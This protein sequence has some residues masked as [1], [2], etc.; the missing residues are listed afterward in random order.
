MGKAVT[1]G[2]PNAERF[3]KA[4]PIDPDEM[5][6][7]IALAT[8]AATYKMPHK[9][10]VGVPVTL[11]MGNGEIETIKLADIPMNRGM[12]AIKRH[13]GNDGEKFFSA[14]LRFIALGAVYTD[15]RCE[16]YVRDVPEDERVWDVSAAIG[17]VAGV[18]PLDDHGTFDLDKF[19]SLAEEINRT[20]YAD[21]D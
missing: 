7:I 8:A 2:R 1:K 21:E 13:C 11:D 6:F 3:R 20:K 4:Q 19:F 10:P 12:M 5:N 16:Q 14:S 17:H 9:N 18:M 15:K